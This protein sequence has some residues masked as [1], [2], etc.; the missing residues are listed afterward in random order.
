[1]A[2]RIGADMRSV[3]VHQGL[4]PV[5][6]VVR[7]AR[8]GRV[9]ET[10]GED[11]YL[12]GRI[13]TAYVRGLE[14]AGVVATLKHFVGYSASKAGRNLAPVSVGPRELADVLLPPF[15]MA[16]RE[17]GVRSVMNSYTDIDGVPSAGDADPADRAAARHLGLRRHRG[18]RLLRDRL[19]HAPARGRRRLGGRRR[20]ALTAGIDVELPTV[21]TYGRAAARRRDPGSDASPSR[22]STARCGACSDRRSS[23]ACSTRSGRRCPPR[24]PEPTLDDAEALRGTRRPRL[25]REPGARPRARRAGDRA[26][27]ERRHAAAFGAEAH[28]RG[29]PERRR[30]ATR[31]SAAT[32][33]PRTWASTIRRCRSGIELPTVL[34]AV[35]AEFP[36]R[37][38]RATYAARR[39][40]AARPTRFA[41]A[42]AGG[43]RRR[44]RHPRPRRPG[45]PVRPRH[46]R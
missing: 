40:T 31:C 30:P 21:K 25:R 1:M 24:S 9:E 4:A 18:R 36:G 19:P 43:T 34:D 44:R 14:S 2:E 5:L 15:E 28:R 45:R 22:S 42:V 32:R 6:D 27:H 7:D 16:I 23:S 33:S 11:P 10:I 38:A 20:P 3:G 46:E 37:R 12:V 29:R 41:A 39:S 8:W 26:A 13:G 17:G 35:R